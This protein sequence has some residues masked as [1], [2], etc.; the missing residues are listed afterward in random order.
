MRSGAASICNWLSAGVMFLVSHL[1][2]E[3]PAS[4]DKAPI[5]LAIYCGEK[6][7]TAG[8]HAYRMMHVMLRTWHDALLVELI[9]HGGASGGVL[10]QGL[11]KQDGSRDVLAQT[12]GCAEQLAVCLQKGCISTTGVFACTCYKRGRLQQ[13]PIR[14]PSQKYD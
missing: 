14:A 1:D 8:L 5:V 11:L 10:V 3:F 13:P 6:T 7:K 2:L 12:G 4:L 9:H